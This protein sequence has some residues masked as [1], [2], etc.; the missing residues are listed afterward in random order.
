MERGCQSKRGEMQQMTAWV[1]SSSPAAGVKALPVSRALL[2]DLGLRVHLWQESRHLSPG[3]AHPG[4]RRSLLREDAEG[5]RWWYLML[6]SKVCGRGE[7]ET[8][9]KW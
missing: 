5:R 2:P 8:E 7:K 4:E 3:T 6:Q 9:L 1:E